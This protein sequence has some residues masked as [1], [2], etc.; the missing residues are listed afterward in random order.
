[1]NF[2]SGMQDETLTLQVTEAVPVTIFVD[3]Y[4]ATGGPFSVTLSQN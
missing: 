3:A 2:Q 1:V 4:G